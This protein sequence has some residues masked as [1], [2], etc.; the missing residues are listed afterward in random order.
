MSLTQGIS[1]L[2]PRSMRRGQDSVEQMAEE[3]SEIRGIYA[4]AAALDLRSRN[5]IVFI[6][7]IMGSRLVDPRDS[8]S[9]W[10]DFNR[11]YNDPTVGANRS[12]IALPMKPGIPLDE[13][14]APTEADGAMAVARPRRLPIAV[15][16]YRDIMQSVGVEAGHPAARH[17]PQYRS[18]EGFASFEFGYD[19]RR[20]LDETARE[21]ERFLRLAS[22]FV[23]A[24]RGNSDPVK[25]DIV[26]HSMGG[27]VLRYFLQYGAQRLP[28]DGSL[29]RLT[30]KGAQHVSRAIIVGTPNAGSVSA[31]ERLVAGLPARRL[32]H[33]GFDPFIVGTMPALYQLLPRN[34]HRPFRAQGESKAAVDL[35][36]PDFWDRMNWGLANDD[37]DRLLARQ[38]EDLDSPGK[39]REAALDHLRKCLLTAK[40]FHAA[41][42][43]PAVPPESLEFHLV[44]GDA[45]PTV[46]EVT[47]TPGA[48][49][50]DVLRH[51]AGDATVL[52]SSALL[53]E[54]SGQ[55][56]QPHVQSPIHWSSVMFATS[57]HMALTRDRVV[58]DNVLFRLF[59]LAPGD[60][61]GRV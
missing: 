49:H 52:R 16:A 38:L 40:S 56:W 33:P 25:F 57:N 15:S 60:R 12:L 45:H 1:K 41:M 21:L 29:P 50:V 9:I 61:E 42:D 27:L 19:W 48:P 7:G 32:V 11:T 13:L 34:R 44:A 36:A 3:V 46:A 59:E 47:G 14:H 37:G 23:R 6:P 8:R 5:P 28:L 35:F 51:A 22:Y 18:E 39:R 17:R 55:S 24:A 43:R 20:S 26:A 30:W 54:R 4:K 10:G 2:L 58:I 53:D 31:I